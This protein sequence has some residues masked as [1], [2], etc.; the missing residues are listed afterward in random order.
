[1]I[2]FGALILY[3]LASLLIMPSRQKQ[4]ISEAAHEAQR[5]TDRAARLENELTQLRRKVDRFALTA[6]A[7]WELIKEKTELNEQDLVKRMDEIDL[8]DGTQDGKIG[9]EVIEC[10]ECK[11]PVSSARDVC[12]YCGAAIDRKHLFG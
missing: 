9:T 11:R 8:R 3:D 10:P 1:L 4:Q 5:A 6:Q 12:M 2:D 7:M